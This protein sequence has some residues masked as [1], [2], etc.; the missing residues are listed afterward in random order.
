MSARALGLTEGRGR[1]LRRLGW[2]SL[3]AMLAIGSVVMLRFLWPAGAA[4][5][6]SR[7]AATVIV[8][9]SATHTARL[10][11]RK[12]RWEGSVDA[13]PPRSAT[14]FQPSGS[15]GFFVV[16][17][18]DG[19]FH[20]FAD[21]SPHPTAGMVQ[22]REP[23]LR[24]LYGWQNV[25]K[26]WDAGLEDR[27]SLYLHDGTVLSGP[28]PRLDPFPLAAN[29]G[30]VNVARYASCPHDEVFSANGVRNSK[31]RPMPT[32]TIVLTAL[33]ASCV[34]S[35][36]TLTVALLVL[37]PG[38]RAA[39][40]PQAPTSTVRTQKLEIVDQRGR[41]RAAM[42]T[43]YPLSIRGDDRN[44]FLNLDETPVYLEF[45]DEHERFRAGLHGLAHGSRL[46][47]VDG[48]GTWRTSLWA[49]GSAGPEQHD[50]AGLEIS[51]ARVRDRV[52]IGSV[53]PQGL[54]PIETNLAYD[55]PPPVPHTAY[56]RDAD[57][58]V[59]WQAP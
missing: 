33:I 11:Q 31:E 10:V 45:F 51:D 13:F 16:R 12:D 15:P 4:E 42:G 21:R 24:G 18:P 40:D 56:L 2:G 54:W 59:I 36:V 23:L 41:V 37:A 39:P 20:A 46:T 58:R 38:I 6:S 32:R 3:L 28:G 1:L 26:G 49:F 53:L 47:L 17:E 22:W 50:Y 57:G 52:W 8:D 44:V 7:V 29:E 55:P 27:H 30:Y 19:A 48:Y 9:G 34:S 43:R 14:H 35:L 5:A 25:I